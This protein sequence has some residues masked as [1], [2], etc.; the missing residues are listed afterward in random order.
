MKTKFYLLLSILFLIVSCSKSGNDV[1]EP[2]YNKAEIDQIIDE[3]LEN[4]IQVFQDS[5]DA[6]KGFLGWRNIRD[7]IG[8]GKE[9]FTDRTIA[10][11]NKVYDYEELETII[12]INLLTDDRVNLELTN[13]NSQIGQYI[14]KISLSF[15]VLVLEG[16]FESLLSLFFGFTFGAVVAFVYVFYKFAYGG[17]IRWSKNRRSRLSKI[18]STT[19]TIAS[20]TA[21]IV[22]II[23][24]IINGD[25]SDKALTNKIK[26]DIQKEISAQIEKNI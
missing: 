19:G 11:W 5:M 2:K 12:E 10:T 6:K 18:L 17:W 9:T 4:T 14:H 26:A 23:S 22:V 1:I 25:Y 21:V 20:F 16:L 15:F 13:S 7:Y 8:L 3:H 24:G